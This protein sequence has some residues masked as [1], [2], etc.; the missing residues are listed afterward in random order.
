MACKSQQ[1][2]TRVA[3]DILRYFL[4]NPEAADDLEGIARWRLLEEK[5]HQSLLETGRALDWL[6]EKS[7]LVAETNAGSGTL[8]RL[9]KSKKGEIE[10]LLEAS[11]PEP[12]ND[13]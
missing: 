11:E 12:N 9:N 6:L 4:R 5:V 8:F 1:S 7:L 13:G 10:D 2:E 3:R